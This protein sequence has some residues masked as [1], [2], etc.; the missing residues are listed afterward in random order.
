MKSMVGNR[1]T[2]GNKK[3]THIYKLRKQCEAMHVINN[4]SLQKACEKWWDTIEEK[5]FMS[6]LEGRTQGKLCRQK[7]C[8]F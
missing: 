6:T 7:Q 1:Q 4:I 5:D 2:Y 8:N 3:L